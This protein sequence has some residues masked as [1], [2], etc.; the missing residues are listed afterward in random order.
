MPRESAFPI[1]A[2]YD[3]YRVLEGCMDSY[4]NNLSALTV[5]EHGLTSREVPLHW[6]DI[7]NIVSI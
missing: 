7:R 2:G 5:N 6:V 4:I 3:L 1:R